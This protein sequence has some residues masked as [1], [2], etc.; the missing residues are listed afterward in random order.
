MGAVDRGVLCA[1]CGLSDLSCPGHP[2]HIELDF[3]VYHPLLFTSVFQLVRSSCSCCHRLRLSNARIWPYVAKLKLLEM[4]DV[5]GAEEIDD[6]LLPQTLFDD[7]EQD[8]EGEEEPEGEDLEES[9]AMDEEKDENSSDGGAKKPVE[10]RGKTKTSRAAGSRTSSSSSSRGSSGNNAASEPE[11]DTAEILADIDARFKA[12]CGRKT[13]RP[14]GVFAR[15]KQQE[16]VADFQRECIKIKKCEVC[17]ERSPTIR[18]DGHT[19]MFAKPLPKSARV[20]AKNRLLY[21]GYSALEYLQREEAGLAIGVGANGDD[22]D[23]DSAMQ[24]DEED[25]EDDGDEDEDEDEE[26]EEETKGGEVAAKEKDNKKG[27]QGG[28]KGSSSSTKNKKADTTGDRYLAPNEVEAVLKLLWRFHPE[29]LDAIHGR[30]Q[31][32]L[33]ALHAPGAHGWNVFFL[34]AILVP[35]NRFRP[36][37]IVGDTQSDHPQNLNL[38][39]IID[40]NQAIRNLFAQAARG[41]GDDDGRVEGTGTGGGTSLADLVSRSADAGVHS[42]S[43]AM[44]TA[45]EAHA[46]A[47]AAAAQDRKAASLLSQSL[48]LLIQLQNHVN[49]YMDSSKDP[50]PLGGAGQTQP[51]IRQILER[52]QGLFR[53]N[54]MGK[55]VNYCCRSVISPDPYIGTNEVGLPLHFAKSLHY[56]EPVNEYNVKR[57]RTLVERGPF[58]YPGKY[59]TGTGIGTSCYCHIVSASAS[60]H[61]ALLFPFS[62]FSPSL[63][64]SFALT[65]HTCWFFTTT[66]TPTAAQ[67]RSPSEEES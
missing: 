29:I 67:G 22:S 18:K 58:Q 45:T 42:S 47:S 10:R 35:A 20:S 6:K 4:D 54:M 39:K 44:P 62:F 25:E 28:G 38:A 57:L 7:I 14:P 65:R 3:P 61:L 16:V 2:G 32:G 48:G 31:R 24:E 11:L 9:M 1:T 40:T 23:D 27:K 36:E 21:G 30:S 8:G 37:A 43:G 26:G 15:N 5:V 56:P 49:C 55:R 50:N 41:E 13:R 19:K 51:G 52:K 63:L 17:G 12:Y 46:A 64:D 53:Q 66:T 34:R 59:N 60:V 33:A